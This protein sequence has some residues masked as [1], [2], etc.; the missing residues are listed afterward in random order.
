[1]SLKYIIRCW[2]RGSH[3]TCEQF[4]WQLTHKYS[5]SPFY[6]VSPACVQGP[7]YVRIVIAFTSDFHCHLC[8]QLSVDRSVDNSFYI[9]GNIIDRKANGQRSESFFSCLWS[10]NFPMAGPERSPVD[11]RIISGNWGKLITF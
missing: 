2:I 11:K 6:I 9:I 3:D 4:Y 7:L 1:M 5:I 10:L 8:N